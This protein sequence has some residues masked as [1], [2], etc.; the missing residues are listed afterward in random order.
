MQKVISALLIIA[1]IIHLL[2]LSGVLGAERLTTLYGL[3]F[4]EPNLLILMRSRAVL[5]G[6]L[7]LFLLYAALR[8]A[9]QPIA[10][11]GGLVSVLSFLV[12]A[13]SS[14]GYNEALRRVVIADWV[15]LACL[16]VAALLYFLARGKA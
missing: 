10:L 6:L 9:L 15:A 3:A 5:F 4:Q 16:V 1:G 12:L 8:P 2:P 11:L 14:P 7:G 13:W